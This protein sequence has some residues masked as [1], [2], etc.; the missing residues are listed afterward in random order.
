M[1][2]PTLTLQQFL[3][4]TL[5]PV[6]RENPSAIRQQRALYQQYCQSVRLYGDAEIKS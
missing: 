2:K 4:A 6:E 3:A 5:S 1:T